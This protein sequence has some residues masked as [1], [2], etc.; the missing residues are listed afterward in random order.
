MELLE[1]LFALVIFVGVAPSLY[2]LV[3]FARARTY[4]FWLIVPVALLGGYLPFEAAKAAA[5]GADSEMFG[6][7]P[8][9]PK[10][11]LWCRVFGFVQL[12]LVAASFVWGEWRGSRAQRSSDGDH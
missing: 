5:K 4:R 3:I 2:A 1:A 7:S 11:A 6:S 9:D 8:A 10:A 12:G